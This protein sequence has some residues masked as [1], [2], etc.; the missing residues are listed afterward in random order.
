MFSNYLSSIEGISLYPVISLFIFLFA[1][2]G[3]IIWIFRVDTAYVKQM[4][5][6]PLDQEDEYEK[7]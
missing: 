7:K 2:V 1:F 6:L 4:E 3:M 5:S